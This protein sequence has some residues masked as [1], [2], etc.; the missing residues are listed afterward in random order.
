MV[1]HSIV[2]VNCR[3]AR[4]VMCHP[5]LLGWVS[6][7]SGMRSASRRVARFCKQETSHVVWLQGEA[8]ARGGADSRG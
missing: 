2:P 4:L 5:S 8:S 3:V 6:Q 1:G 7:V